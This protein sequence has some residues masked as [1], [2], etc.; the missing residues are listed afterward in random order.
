MFIKSD[1]ERIFN[2]EKVLIGNRDVM[3]EYKANKIFGKK[4]VEFAKNSRTLGDVYNVYGAGDFS[5]SYFTLEG[6]NIAATY[7][8]ICSIW[9]INKEEGGAAV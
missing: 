7:V 5:C 6:I 2:R 4:A 1:V 9:D 8:N 3:P